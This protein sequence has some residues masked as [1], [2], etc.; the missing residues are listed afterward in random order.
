MVCW[1]GY[2]RTMGVKGLGFGI[3]HRYNQYRHR[4]LVVSVSV[5]N[6]LYSREKY[7]ARAL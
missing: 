4:G 6:D 3:L 5:A 1:Q 7:M 2:A